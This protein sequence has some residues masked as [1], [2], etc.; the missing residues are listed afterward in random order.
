ME[1]DISFSSTL[2]KSSYFTT[3]GAKY[4]HSSSLPS[5]GMNSNLSRALADEVRNEINMLAG[6]QEVCQFAKV[7]SLRNHYAMI[8]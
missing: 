3:S 6:S 2:G 7:S 4:K 8:T 5:G 1:N